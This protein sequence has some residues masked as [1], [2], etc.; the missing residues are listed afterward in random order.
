MFVYFR[1]IWKI[2]PSYGIFYTPLVFAFSNNLVYFSTFW[3]IVFRKIWQHWSK[4]NLTRK[5][6]W[7]KMTSKFQILDIFYVHSH[8]FFQALFT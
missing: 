6:I 5:P 1:V 2:F 4:M 7:W 8:V 3:F